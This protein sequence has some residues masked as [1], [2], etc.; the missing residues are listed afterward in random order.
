VM[1]SL[2]GM[3]SSRV[4]QPVF[5]VAYLESDTIPSPEERLRFPASAY[6]G[7]DLI[8]AASHNQDDQRLRFIYSSSVRGAGAIEKLCLTLSH[9]LKTATDDPETGIY[10]LGAS[11]RSAKPVL[12]SE[13]APQFSF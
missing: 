6:G 5:R 12:S 3:P 7:L 11:S 10:Q 13:H 2:R 8:L 9:V 1:L 4:S